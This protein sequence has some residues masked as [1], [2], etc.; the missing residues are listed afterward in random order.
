MAVVLLVAQSL[1]VFVPWR[2]SDKYYRYIGTGPMMRDVLEAGAWPADVYVVQGESHP[3]YAAAMIYRAPDF[4]GPGPI[5]VY[6][7]GT[8][9]GSRL[10]Q[11][12][13]NRRIWRIEGPG[14]TGDVYRIIGPMP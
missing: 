5:I 2:S 3:D 7:T 8:N 12:F 14:R 1:L 13:P 9:V 6:D 4:V 11:A 10:R